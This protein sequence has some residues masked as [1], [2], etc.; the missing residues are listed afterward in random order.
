MPGLFDME[1][2]KLTHLRMDAL[3]KLIQLAQKRKTGARALRSILEE[4]LLSTL[5]E[6][7][8]R[9]DISEVISYGRID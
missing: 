3:D 7:P 5:Y 9:K 4:V 6:V 2:V 1:G 8:G